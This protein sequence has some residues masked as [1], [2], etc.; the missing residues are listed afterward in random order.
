MNIQI[1]DPRLPQKFWNNVTPEPNSGCWLWMGWVDR[2]G[3]GRTRV[4]RETGMKA[5]KP[6]TISFLS[7]V[8][9]LPVWADGLDH[10]C[11]TRS[12]C[13]PAHLRPATAKMQADNI[14][15]AGKII[16]SERARKVGVRM[17]PINGINSS[18]GEK[19]PFHKLTAKDVA[20]IR[21]I[22]MSMTQRRLGEMYGVSGFTI[23]K[24]RTNQ[25]WKH[26]T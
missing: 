18:A 16:S 1:D 12:C 14:S 20:E 23:H 17:G 24:I 5:R 11:H 4:F 13:N 8:G 2:D 26:V 22:G 9:E 15:A 21:T 25:K 7:F 10:L 3:Y 6:H 19:S